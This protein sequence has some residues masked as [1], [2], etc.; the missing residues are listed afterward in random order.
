MS[1]L[2]P[3]SFREEPSAHLG[4]C[5]LPGNFVFK[6]NTRNGTYWNHS[7]SLKKRLLGNKHKRKNRSEMLFLSCSKTAKITSPD[8]FRNL[9]FHVIFSQNS[10]TEQKSPIKNSSVSFTYDQPSA[11]SDSSLSWKPS[12][13]ESCLQWFVGVTPLWSKVSSK[14][15]CLY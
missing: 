13:E 11:N 10:Q 6:G 7:E 15:H 2:P 8:L 12:T 4:A 1:Y 9:F 3:S 14:T 5:C